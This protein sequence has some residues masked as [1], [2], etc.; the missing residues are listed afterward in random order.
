MDITKIHG[1][2][3]QTFTIRTK[4]N[5]ASYP[6]ANQSNIIDYRKTVVGISFRLENTENSRSINDVRLIN[7]EVAKG[8]FL[9]LVDKNN[10]QLV[11][12]Q[13]LFGFVRADANSDVLLEP[14]QID[15]KNSYIN[16]AEYIVNDELDQREIEFTVY[17]LSNCQTPTQPNILLDSGVRYNAVKK[18]AIQVNFNENKSELVSTGNPIPANATI[19]G[20]SIPQYNN[21]TGFGNREG[22]NDYN[23]LGAVFVNLLQGTDNIFRNLPIKELQGF[24]HLGFKYFPIEQVQS[25]NIDW[26]RFKLEYSNKELVGDDTCL[27]IN[28]HYYE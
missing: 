17:Y 9:T 1:L 3:S 12:N 22:I 7:E 18:M 2:I 5:I 21:Y 20:F 14:C 24:E 6:L 11:V 4:N 28:I 8:G 19:V 27:L 23:G 26:N 15:F 16:F 10:R 25:N 13:N